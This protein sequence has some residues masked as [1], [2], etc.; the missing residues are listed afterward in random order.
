M[1]SVLTLVS[2]DVLY[3]SQI[4]DKLYMIGDNCQRTKI[5]Y[6]L[7][8]P[9]ISRHCRTTRAGLGAAPHTAD[10]KTQR[11][12]PEMSWVVKLYELV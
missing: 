12:S 7:L 6:S 9:L 4:C 2:G 3:S 5:F 8:P 11:S 10:C 1:F